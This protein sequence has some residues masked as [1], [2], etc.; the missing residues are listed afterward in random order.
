MEQLNDRI[1]ELKA[2]LPTDVKHLVENDNLK[3]NSK[4]P[5]NQYTNIFS[6]LFWKGNLSL[7]DYFKIRDDY[8]TRNPYLDLFEKHLGL[9]DKLGGKNG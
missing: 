4:Y 2:S 5:F 3:K 7:D 8:F 6:V 9:S 1:E